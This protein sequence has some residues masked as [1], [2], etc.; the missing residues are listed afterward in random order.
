ME[1]Q[2]VPNY[3]LAQ[4]WGGRADE[5]LIFQGTGFFVAPNLILTARHVGKEK[6]NNTT[7]S[8]SHQ[9]MA[10][11]LP[12][13]DSFIECREEWCS[14][15]R[16]IAILKLI[17]NKTWFPERVISLITGVCKRNKSAWSKQ[18]WYT[19]GFPQ[20]EKGQGIEDGII[21]NGYIPND[22]Q[23]GYPRRIQFTCS[24]LHGCS[25]SPIVAFLNEQWYCVGVMYLGG[26]GK[27]NSMGF[28][29]DLVADSLPSRLTRQVST[30]NIDTILSPS[31]NVN[32]SLHMVISGAAPKN[33]KTFLQRLQTN[34]PNYALLPMLPLL[35][36]ILII[37]IGW[38]FSHQIKDSQKTI[39][40]LNYTNTGPH[41]LSKNLSE[42]IRERIEYYIKM[43]AG[44]FG[45]DENFKVI[46]LAETAHSLSDA[47]Q[48]TARYPGKLVLWGSYAEA[49][50]GELIIQTNFTDSAYKNLHIQEVQRLKAEGELLSNNLESLLGKKTLAILHLEL[51]HQARKK[52]QINQAA[53]HYQLAEKFDKPFTD[54]ESLFNIEDQC[55]C[56]RSNI[57]DAYRF[58]SHPE[59]EQLFQLIS[60]SLKSEDRIGTGRFH[61]VK[62][63]YYADRN[64]F[65]AAEQEIA[66]AKHA[67]VG[68]NYVVGMRKEWCIKA[69][70]S[71]RAGDAAKAE[72]E[73]LRCAEDME[74]KGPRDSESLELGSQAHFEVGKL[75]IRQ[76]KYTNARAHLDESLRFLPSKEQ[77]SEANYLISIIED[78]EG[79]YKSAL[80]GIEH[81]NQALALLPRPIPDA[82]LGL[83]L[84]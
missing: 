49:A 52:Q 62:A 72:H 44:V 84:S 34:L 6:V 83:L 42:I 65:S 33:Q 67:Y 14:E 51:G 16:D 38:H 66:Q 78:K 63:C 20:S 1:E 32:T 26:D 36:V 80:S 2:K 74:S 60:T 70:I 25:G 12:G 7:S 29:A 53:K 68:S 35:L 22:N 58:I 11:C 40:I 30:V 56:T 50:S 46:I 15:N 81:S 48:I 59:T 24:I 47:Q 55:N 57:A 82:L 3:F 73:W 37:S 75:L 10:I 41:A 23:K 61:E 77:K 39:A 64:D 69:S 13:N 19:I 8:Y 45:Y 54:P 17:G 31:M 71:K 18:D 43:Q 79:S 9:K 4:I 21:E 27:T 28:T 76:E 5:D